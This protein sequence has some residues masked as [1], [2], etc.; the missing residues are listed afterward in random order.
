MPT[1]V[2]KRT[3]V[4]WTQARRHAE[5]LESKRKSIVTAGGHALLDAANETV[6]DDP[7]T[8][9]GDLKSTGF[10]S[11]DHRGEVVV[12]Y[13]AVYALRQHEVPMKHQGR[14]RWKWLE[15]TAQERAAASAIEESVADET[16]KA[17][18]K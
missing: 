18:K 1:L 9:S 13:R 11:V 7:G 15:K 2:V 4:D 16:R 17:M 12:G 10:V 14:G 6:P 3:E 5:R 8:P